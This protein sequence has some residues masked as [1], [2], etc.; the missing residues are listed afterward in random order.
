MTGTETK[1]YSTPSEMYCLE[2]QSAQEPFGHPD[3]G[4][5][6]TAIKKNLDVAYVVLN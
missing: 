5:I 3:R 2:K 4:K 1:K 6:E